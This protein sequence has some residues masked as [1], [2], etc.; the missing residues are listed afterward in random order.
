[1]PRPPRPYHDPRERL[2][3]ETLGF[4]VLVLIVTPVAALVGGLSWRL[5]RV[6]AGL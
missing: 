5:F 1:M 3:Y 4:A 2:L 6:V